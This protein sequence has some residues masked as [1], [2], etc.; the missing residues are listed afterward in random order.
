MD[1][2]KLSDRLKGFVQSAQTLAVREGNPQITPEHLLKVLLEEHRD[3]RS[4]VR[5]FVEEAQITGQLQHP[6][7]VPIYEIGLQADARPY[8]AMKLVQGRTLAAL[9]RERQDLAVDRRKLLGIFEQICQTM[10]YAHSRGVIHRDLKPANVMVGSFGE[11]QIVDWGLAKVLAKSK[12]EG[13]P[14]LA[15]PEAMQAPS[16]ATQRGASTSHSV[17]GAVMGTPA[18]M[19]PEQASGEKPD[20]KAANQLMCEA[21][22]KRPFYSVNYGCVNVRAGRRAWT[23]TVLSQNRASSPCSGLPRLH[24]QWFGNAATS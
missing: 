20:D 15:E 6:G 10:T 9:L 13:S 24:R 23:T 17:A 11:V 16:P 18:Y 7:V 21:R 8:F 5:R 12:A 14:S 1:F 2:E 4:I 22:C 19:P 3:C